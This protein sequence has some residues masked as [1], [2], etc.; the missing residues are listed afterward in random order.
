MIIG[1][2]LGDGTLVRNIKRKYIFSIYT[3]PNSYSL[4]SPYF[5]IFV[6][7][8]IIIVILDVKEKIVT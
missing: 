1:L 6:N 7:Y 5:N 3:K 2:I 8:I 4:Y